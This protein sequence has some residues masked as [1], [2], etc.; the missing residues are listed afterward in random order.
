MA[1][2]VKLE[3]KLVVYCLIHN[4]EKFIISA[5]RRNW[6]K[7]RLPQYGDDVNLA[8]TFD[9]AQECE[10]FISELHNPHYREFYYKKAML[11]AE[12]PVKL[13][14]NDFS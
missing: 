11:P 6:D 1:K 2:K 5:P 10:S 8:I 9:T 14:E 13:H 3:E 7:K 12:R 4:K